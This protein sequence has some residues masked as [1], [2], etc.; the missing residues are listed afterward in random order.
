MGLVKDLL[1]PQIYLLQDKGQFVYTR[2]KIRIV[3]DHLELFKDLGAYAEINT[4]YLLRDRE[5]DEANYNSYI[6]FDLKQSAI[7]VIPY[8]TTSFFMVVATFILIATTKKNV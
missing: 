1:I 7:A 8:S 2:G 3:F 6:V 5:V 4:L